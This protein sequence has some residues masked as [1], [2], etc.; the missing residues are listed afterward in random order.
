[1]DRQRPKPGNLRD[2]CPPA[3]GRLAFWPCLVWANI[4]VLPGFWCYGQVSIMRCIFG[5]LGSETSWD[6]V[7]WE[8]LSFRDVGDALLGDRSETNI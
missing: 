3:A 7:W 2:L 8:R 1:M 6:G 4:L 5:Q